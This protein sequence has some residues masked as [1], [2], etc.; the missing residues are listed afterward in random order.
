[1]RSR[2]PSWILLVY[3]AI[4]LANPFVPGAFRFTPEEGLVWVEAAPHSR[5]AVDPGPR[6]GGEI[7]PVPR[8][9]ASE[10]ER[11]GSARARASAASRRLAGRVR[12]GDP[13][14]RDRPPPDADDH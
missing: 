10:G 9:P 3:L 4:D 7:R 5:E 2:L 13:P 8:R 11:R 1:M 14:A 12:T 6:G